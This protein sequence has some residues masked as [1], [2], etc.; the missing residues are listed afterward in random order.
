MFVIEEDIH[1][2]T[3]DDLLNDTL[4]RESRKYNEIYNSILVEAEKQAKS[5]EQSH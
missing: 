5:A 4:D 1:T 3:L 2:I